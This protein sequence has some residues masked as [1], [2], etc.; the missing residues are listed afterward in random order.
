MRWSE[1]KARLNAAYGRASAKRSPNGTPTALRPRSRHRVLKWTGGVFVGVIAV[2]LVVLATLDWNRMRGPV[3]YFLSARLH[4]EVRIDGDLK[5]KLFSWTPAAEANG[6]VIAQPQWVADANP[7]SAGPFANVRRLT[8]SLDLK[9]L[10][11]W[12]VE[13]PVVDADQP[14]LKLVRD[15]SGRSNWN[16]DESNTQPFR[17][18]L[19]RHFVIR[20]GQLDLADAKKNMVFTGT[21]SSEEGDSATGSQFFSLVGIGELNHAPFSAEV[22]GDPLLNIQPGEPYAFDGHVRA[23]ATRID[24]K[25]SLNKPFDLGLFHV[26]ATFAGPN[27]ADLYY[28]TGLALPNTPPYSLSGDLS[29]EGKTFAFHNLGG[30]V[31]DSDL[32]GE[33]TVDGSGDKPYL[34]AD[35]ASQ[36]LNFDD[37]GPLIGARPAKDAGSKLSPPPNPGTAPAPSGILPDL[38]LHVERLRQMDADVH[39]R[40]ATVA[41]RD[42]PLRMAETQLSLKDGVLKLTPVTF[43]FARGALTGDVQIDARKDVPVSDIDVRLTGLRLEQFMPAP[44]GTPPLT[45]VA[46]ARAKLRGAGNSIRKAA[47]TANGTF[48]AVVPHGAIRRSFAELLGINVASALGLLLTND[49]SQTELRC[50]VADFSAN[51]GV[52]SLRNF[53]F[54]TPVVQAS[55]EGTVDLRNERIDLAITGH[56][57]KP[58]L[59]R[60]RAPITITGPMDHPAIGVNAGKRDRARW[61]G[62]G[63]CHRVVAA[64]LGLAVRR[65]GSG[66]GCRLRRAV[67]AGER[68]RRPRH[69]TAS[70]ALNW[71]LW[72]MWMDRPLAPTG[73]EGWGEGVAPRAPAENVISLG[74]VEV[75]ANTAIAARG[76]ANDRT[77]PSLRQMRLAADPVHGA[78]LRGEL[79][80][81]GECRLRR[82]HHEQGFGLLA[83][84]LRVRRGL[85]FCRL[86]LFMVPANVILERIG[87]RRWIFC[88][89]AVWGL[90]SAS[91]ALV[92]SPISFYV[93]RFLLGVAEAGFFPGMVLYLTYWFPRG[94]RARFDGQFHDRGSV[95][96]RHWRAALQPHS[97]NGRRGRSSRLAM[98]V[99]DRRSAR[100]STRF[101]RAQI[102][103]RQSDGGPL[104]HR[105]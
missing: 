16:F 32:H 53:V 39:Y 78:A 33:L 37:L 63:A 5:V 22:R 104:A 14:Q 52:L 91:N 55:G 28:L 87:A 86:C 48:T 20:E 11:S 80:R 89:L 105:R 84:D 68:A 51:N 69:A 10:L 12:H 15:A 85:F 19:I 64:C 21:L 94:Y 45:G 100:I 41:S 31:G 59:I 4:R 90:L 57:K 98:A 3:G 67:G 29:R 47:S 26:A 66:Q 43:N 25:G 61:I 75:P 40:A 72:A 30:K 96:I 60:V 74:P 101:R 1:F 77:G 23:G 8:I 18:P 6:L 44:S 83:H 81:P 38:P 9:R 103:A 58:Q 49:Q 56:P 50:A 27:L 2:L 62:R 65:S 95:G 92:Q 46:T 7:A 54:D 73:G 93:L 24:A 70:E 17:L 42:F 97:W 34:K 71:N 99:P 36:T 102:F 79:H 88:I 82:A 13:L 76:G 35:L